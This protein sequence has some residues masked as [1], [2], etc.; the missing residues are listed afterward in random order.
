MTTKTH[1]DLADRPFAVV[2]ASGQ[3][4]G[5]TAAALLDAGPSSGHWSATRLLPPQ[6]DLRGGARSS[7]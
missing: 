6:P 4:G 7:P 2:G 1:D 5:A 3:Q